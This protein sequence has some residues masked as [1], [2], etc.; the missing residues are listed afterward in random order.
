MHFAFPLPVWLSVL[1]AA[2]IAAVAYLSYRRPYVTLS[3]A[4]RWS[5]VTLR[6]LALTAVVV[7]LCR[8][9]FVLP[10]RARDAVVPVLVDASQSMRI[11]DVSGR[12]R[13]EAAATLL[14]DQLLPAL[15]KQFTPELYTL[16]ESVQP[17]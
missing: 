8:P 9:V 7:V 4:Q 5:L 3:R 14:K 15:S 13:I 2:A 16:G 1:V 6:A 12:S 11:A 17:A 10:P